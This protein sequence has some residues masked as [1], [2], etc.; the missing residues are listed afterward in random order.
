[1]RKNCE[2][3][4]TIIWKPYSIDIE[5]I[6]SEMD[7]WQYIWNTSKHLYKSIFEA[8]NVMIYNLIT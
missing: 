3:L 4:C 5:E 6:Y 8:Q 7:I 1:M 2:K